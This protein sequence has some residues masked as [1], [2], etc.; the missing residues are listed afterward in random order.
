MAMNGTMASLNLPIRCT[1][2]ITIRAARAQMTIP[3][4]IGSMENAASQACAMV[5]A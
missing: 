1:P 2:P 4:M 3:M 5:L